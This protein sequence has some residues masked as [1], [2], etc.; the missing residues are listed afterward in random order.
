LSMHVGFIV[1]RHGRAHGRNLHRAGLLH[2]LWNRTSAKATALAAE[3]GCMAATT[4]AQ[5]ALECELL[6]ICVSADADVRSIVGSWPRCAPRS[7]PDR[8][9]H[10]L[11]RHCTI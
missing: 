10:G 4:P 3:L 9:L 8:L 1:W 6:V 5:L 11:S 2:G 7:D